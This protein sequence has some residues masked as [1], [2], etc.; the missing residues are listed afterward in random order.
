[1]KQAVYVYVFDTL[2]DWEIG[3]IDAEIHSGRY[4]R[5]DREPLRIVT[6][7]N[8]RKTVV[9]MGGLKIVPDMVVDE[10][11]MNDA[12][13]LILP[14]GNTWTDPVHDGVLSLA[15]KC[16]DTDIVVAAVCG[17]TMGL[18]RAGLLDRRYHTSNALEVLKTVC[19]QYTGEQYYQNTPSVTDGNL[20]T[21][22]GVA[23]LEFA[24]DVLKKL[25]VFLPEALDAWKQLYKTFEAKYFFELMRLTQ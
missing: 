20:I 14:G 19:P 22:S 7:G 10:F 5:K 11:N 2:A 12:A 15:G 16:L 4:F 25:D 8:S 3:Y 17:A 23:P 13:A 1:M 9:T 18:A 21:A 6:M 24:A